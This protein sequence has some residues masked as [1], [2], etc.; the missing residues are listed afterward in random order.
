MNIKTTISISEA[1]KNIFDIAEEVQKPNNYYTFTENGKPKVV[2]MS[3]EDFESWQETREV[4]SMF[5]NLKRESEEARKEYEAGECV[6]L[7]DYLAKEGFVI[8]K[9]GLKSNGVSTLARL[10]SAKR[11]R[12]SR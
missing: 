10:K 5:P 11:T 4:T 8:G 12:K 3:A 6:T 7:E 9:R 2:L 1:R